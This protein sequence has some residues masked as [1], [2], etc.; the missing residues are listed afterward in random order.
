MNDMTE[1]KISAELKRKSQDKTGL[2]G[3]SQKCHK[4]ARN[5]RRPEIDYLSRG[6]RCDKHS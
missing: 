2:D 4:P 1:V 3:G 5:S 6:R